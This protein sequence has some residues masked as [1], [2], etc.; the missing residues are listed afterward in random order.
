MEGQLV[1]CS[2]AILRFCSEYDDTAAVP[3]LSIQKTLAGADP[4]FLL[5]YFRH[6]VVIEQGTTLASIFLAIEPRKAPLTAWLDR[7]VGA[8][9]DEV[10]SP[11]ARHPAISS[12]LASIAGRRFIA[13]INICPGKRT[14]LYRI[15]LIV[16][17][18]SPMNSTLKATVMRQGLSRAMNSAGASV[19]ISIKLKICR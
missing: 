9:I 8:Y 16:S 4:Y 5:K 11:P 17:K 6:R 19:K 18:L 2:D 13:L 10:K 15:I 1:F 3:L 7:D 12:G 14:S